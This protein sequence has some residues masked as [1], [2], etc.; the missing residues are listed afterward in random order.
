MRLALALLA[1]LMP[2][3]LL[4]APALSAEDAQTA[5]SP[6]ERVDLERLRRERKE[7]AARFSVGSRISRYQAAAAKASDEGRP[8]EALALLARLNPKRLNPYERALVHRLEAYISYAAGDY[9]AAIE[10]FQEA[11]D[12]KVFPLDVDNKIR[13]GIAQLY[14]SQQK[15]P[16]TIEA[17]GEWFRYADEPTPLAYYLRAIARYQTG[18]VEH[19]IADAE[20][21]VDSQAEP[22]EGWLQLL[23]ALYIQ[24]EDYANATP[25]LEELVMRFTKKQYWVQLS[26]IYAARD[27]YRASLAVQQVAYL[28][29]FLTE[30]K[31][32]RRLARSYLYHDLP[33][34]AA[35]VLQKALDAGQIEEDADFFQLLANSWIA[36]RNYDRSLEPL[37]RAA[38]LSDD[39]DLYVRLAQV[40]LQREDWEKATQYLRLALEKGGLED[41][42]NARLLLGIAYYNQDRVDL[43]RNAFAR[44]SEYE[45]TRSKAKN[46]IEHI[47]KEARAS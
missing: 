43:A 1:L 32:L 22:P 25:V 9:E 14:A 27:D 21:A 30:D 18:D 40:Y 46:W 24:K 33:Y 11:L 5:R 4:P 20:R 42:G 8:E 35:T 26:L 41:P 12:E 13:F 2:F 29:G 3:A 34:E 17:L 7:Y 15:W 28:Q 6:D 23:A 47:E 31:D 44:A 38:D 36:A 39:G 45:S 19:A 16:E 37:R 10:H